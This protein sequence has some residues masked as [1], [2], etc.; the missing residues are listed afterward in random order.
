MRSE[1][2][3]CRTVQEFFLTSYQ[4]K[5]TQ[6]KNFTFTLIIL[7]LFFGKT[8]AQ[9]PN[10]IIFA[11]QEEIDNFPI[12]YPT[13][14][15]IDQFVEIHGDNITNLNSLNSLTSIGLDLYIADNPSLLTLSGLENLEYV[16]GE[17]YIKGNDALISLSGLENLTTVNGTFCYILENNSLVDL[18]GLGSLT[19]VNFLLIERNPVLTSL[20]GLNNL[21]N[22]EVALHIHKNDSLSNLN[23]LEILTYIK[24][25]L[26]ISNNKNLTDLEGLGNLDSI[27]GSLSISENDELLSISGLDNLQSIGGG[28]RLENC[29][30][31]QN[32]SGL[33]NLNS[34]GNDL[35]IKQCNDLSNLKELE[36]V[37]SIG[38]RLE[39]YENNDLES[40]AGLDS[41]AAGSISDLK[42]TFNPIL[43]TCEVKSICEYLSDPNGDIEIHSNYTG[44]N[45]SVEVESACTVSV[46][47]VELSDKIVI[48]PNPFATSTTIEYELKQA[49]AVQIT[50]HNHLGEM[51]EMIAQYQP[52][53]K[54]Q[55]TWDA[56][57]QPAG[58]YFFRL[59]ADGLL[60]KGKLMLV[61]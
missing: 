18:N 17:L 1:F 28:L 48:Y 25:D 14:T 16:G 41:I 12:Q 39:V 2:F 47:E 9:C 22:I 8:S 61:K 53:G 42:I 20:T 55:I 46:Q 21:N 32:L 45:N 27:G 23:G 57:G 7:C 51:V 6:M 15:E 30:F 33:E 29:F 13:C 36:S 52:Q 5:K 35:R 50:I 56:S 3:N 38:G 59:Y 19:S 54:Q 40:L 24:G 37:H 44:C 31:L 11:S 49:S 4:P 26:I 60:A 34:I 58:M 43:S 10:Y